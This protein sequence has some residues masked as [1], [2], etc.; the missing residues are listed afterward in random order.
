MRDR[1]NPLKQIPSSSFTIIQASHPEFHKYLADI[2]ARYPNG[3]ITYLNNHRFVPLLKL[4]EEDQDRLDHWVIQTFDELIS[5][6]ESDKSAILFIEHG[7]IWYNVDYHDQMVMFNEVCRK[8]AQKGSPVVVL[9]VVM[10]RGLL[11]LE[12]R[13][14]YFYQIGKAA[15]QERQFRYKNQKKLDEIPVGPMQIEER[16]RMYGQMKL[17]EW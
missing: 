8:R 4:K 7:G 12:G 10:D 13:A 2:P 9:T 17:G 3:R 16:G 11:S 6:I 5:T 1:N 15:H 14:D